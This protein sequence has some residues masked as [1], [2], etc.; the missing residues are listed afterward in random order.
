[1]KF[2]YLITNLANGKR[3]ETSEDRRKN[4]LVVYLERT[5]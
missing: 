5:I 1:M 4:V 3:W 2:I